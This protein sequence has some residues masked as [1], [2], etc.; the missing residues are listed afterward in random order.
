MA[1][2]R[3]FP[4]RLMPAP[5][6]A[7]YLGVSEST[8]RNL[9]IPRRQLKAKRLYDKVDLDAFVDGLSYEAVDLIDDTSAADKA[10]GA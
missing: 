9:P 6:A 4:P 2:H 8:L 1:V 5:Q 7:H 10:F 3:D